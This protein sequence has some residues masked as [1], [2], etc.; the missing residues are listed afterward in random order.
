MSRLFGLPAMGMRCCSLMF[1]VLFMASGCGGGGS[2]S[3]GSAES[4]RSL[5]VASQTP[6][7]FANQCYYLKSDEAFLG[8]DPVSGQ[9]MLDATADQAARFYLKPSALGSYLFYDHEQFLLGAH[10]NPVRTQ[11][12]DERLIWQLEQRGPALFALWAADSGYLAKNGSALTFSDAADTALTAEFVAAE[13]CASYPEIGT[14]SEG[15]PI[16]SEFADGA[17]WGLADVHAHLFGTL[18]FGGNVM[19]G[20]VFHPLGVEKALQD[21]RVE[22]GVG[23]KT[24][25]TGFV[26]QADDDEV[27]KQV[28]RL[29]FLLLF[30]QPLHD[31]S[32]YPEFREWPNNRTTT[33]QIA[34]YRWLERAYLGGLRLMVNLL[35]ESGPLCKVGR[36]LSRSYAPVDDQ[37]EFD[38]S[39][40]CNGEATS[41]KQLQAA[42]DLVD[43]ID[44]QHGGPGKGWLRLVS[45]PEAARQVIKNKKLAMV[46]GSETPDLFHCIDGVEGGRSECTPDYIDARLDEYAQKGIQTI[47]PVHHYDNDFGGARVFNPLIE[48]ASVV[49]DGSLFKYDTCEGGYNPVLAIQLPRIYYLLFPDFV[50]D[51]PLFPFVPEGDSF[52]NRRGLTDLGAHLIRG[53]MARGMIIETAHMSR[54]MKE[55]VVDMAEYYDYPLVD[56]HFGKAFEDAL[57]IE[58]RRYLSL[59]G[60]RAP[61]FNRW[62]SVPEY[63]GVEKNCYPYTSQDMAMQ[64]MAFSDTRESLGLDPGVA[65]GSD[66]HGMV[67]QAYPRFGERARCDVPQQ[68]PV[69]YP[70]LSFDGGVRFNRQVS[71]QRIFDYNTDGLAH[72]GL[73][74]D[75]VEDMR[76]QGMSDDYINRFFRG[77]ESYL[78]MWEKARARAASIQ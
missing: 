11:R 23:G 75:V 42:H 74:P 7:Q 57:E 33:H 10:D 17:V 55:A 71:G 73:L 40:V 19:A 22:H 68:N 37:Y 45:T 24:D 51:L 30:N 4:N 70:F 53:M 50:R 5:E 38:D 54:P 21:C 62:V 65:F 9:Y 20:N 6:Y 59:G 76:R 49:Q 56:S 48:V 39:V 43:Y 35:V 61:L 63:Q 64:L 18:A 25:I 28:A 26:T 72:I 52:C 44:A 32:G 27:G 67:K 60:V 1:W 36:E 66:M 46:I 2:G 29:P 77:A 78:K 47:F 16:K 8:I 34:Y 15:E 13:N 41:E 14:N 3:K 12:L 69:T 31:T 58:E